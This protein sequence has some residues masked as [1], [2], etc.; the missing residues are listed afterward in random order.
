MLK[1]KAIRRALKDERVLGLFWSN[2]AKSDGCWL[3]TGK[4]Y[5]KGYG[6]LN[7]F[8][9]SMTVHRLSW[10]I[11][12]GAPP[13]KGMCVCHKCDVRL[14]VRPS[15]LF[16]GTNDDNLRDMRNKGR[17][18]RGSRIYAS[19]LTEEIVREMRGPLKHVRTA[20][21]VERYGIVRSA[22]RKAIRG[23]SWKHVV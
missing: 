2:V 14:C 5:P 13:P 21:L 8:G 19:V 6:M 16:L 23:D 4:R 1:D 18:A 3:W 17:H 20:V 10:A 12:H 9:R 7:A 11:A 15:H 22:I